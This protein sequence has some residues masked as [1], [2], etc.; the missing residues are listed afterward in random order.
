MSFAATDGA[1]MPTHCACG[2]PAVSWF[3]G[4][5]PQVCELLG[6]VLTVTPGVPGRAMCR[7]CNPALRGRDA[8]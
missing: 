3:P 5:A 4:D 2:A 1:A 6:T 8:A 7:E